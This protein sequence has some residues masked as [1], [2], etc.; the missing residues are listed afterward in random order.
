MS[1]SSKPRRRAAIL[2]FLVS[3]LVSL[4]SIG[5][6]CWADGTADP[7]IP[8]PVPDA[9]SGILDTLY[10]LLLKLSGIII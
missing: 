7:P 1:N 10:E 2:A 3:A 9:G 8:L 5:N 4:S 6:C